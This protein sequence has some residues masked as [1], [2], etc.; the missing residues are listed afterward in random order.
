MLVLA[1]AVLLYG[2][3]VVAR[4]IRNWRSELKVQRR[5][6]EEKDKEIVE[7]RDL[8]KVSPSLLKWDKQLSRYD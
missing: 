2:F 5:L 4:R 1:I 6:L 7:L 8:W 3:F